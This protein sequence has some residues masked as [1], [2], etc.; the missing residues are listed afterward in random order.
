MK[1]LILIGSYRK[2]GN[3]DLITRL[4]KD[5]LEENAAQCAETL[6]VETV[7][8]GQSSL[9]PCRGCRACFDRGAEK[10]P[11]QDDFAVLKARLQAADGVLMASPVYV[12]DVSGIT[13][14]WIDR[15]AHVCHRPEFAGKCSYLLVTV[16]SSPTGHAL[17]TLQ[18]A[19]STW[20]FHIA[21]KAGLKTGARMDGAEMK[22]LYQQQAR[23][24]A[25]KLFD[26]IQKK[27]YLRPSFLS[28][29][30]FK[31]QQKAWKKSDPTTLDYHFWHDQHW[32][33]ESCS[34]YIPHFSHPLKTAL[35]RL[36]GELI[37]RFVA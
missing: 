25:H 34:Y 37:F 14:N 5:E 16:G 18:I 23:K 4:I 32:L 2:N 27:A 19:F 6:E 21:G 26:A 10:C 13:K 20:G 24:I 36:A 31:I 7:Y 1:I 35:A 9:L 30:M 11:I 28:L 22:R 8:L 17:Q 12:N 33:D 29:M 15:L 3:T